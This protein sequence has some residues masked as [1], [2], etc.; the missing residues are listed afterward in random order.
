MEITRHVPTD[1]DGP[2]LATPLEENVLWDGV[3]EAVERGETIAGGVAVG[4]EFL[5]VGPL[6]V[7][8]EQATAVL[9]N[10]GLDIAPKNLEGSQPD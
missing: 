8:H 9:L 2:E 10:Q 7:G 6:E 4:A 3:E 5:V 1:A